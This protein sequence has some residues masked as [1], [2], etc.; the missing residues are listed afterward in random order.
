M[1]LYGF[2]VSICRCLVSVWWLSKRKS[3][4]SLFSPG[5]DV[6][7][8]CFSY[9]SLLP[10]TSNN[11]KQFHTFFLLI[12]LSA[13]ALLIYWLIDWSDYLLIVGINLH[14]S[15]ILFRPTSLYLCWLIN[16]MT[17]NVTTTNNQQHN[18]FFFFSF[19]CNALI[20]YAYFGVKPKFGEIWK[21]WAEHNN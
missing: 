10:T 9:I 6:Y 8:P 11:S 13:K 4:H 2:S 18:S 12:Y 3:W 14:L 1:L 7:A 19:L 15:M 21:L 17:C 16:F 20:S 5:A